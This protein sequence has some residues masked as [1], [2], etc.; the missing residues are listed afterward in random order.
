[1]TYTWRPASG[2]DVNAITELTWTIFHEVETI[3]IPDKLTFKRN[4]TF[5]IVNQFFNPNGEIVS[6]AVDENETILAYTWAKAGEK[7]VWSDDEILAIRLAHVDPSL[8]PRV[9]LKLLTDMLDIWESFAKLTNINIISSN[10]MR[11]EQ[12]AFL[13]LHERRGYQIRGSYAYKK[14]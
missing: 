11:K 12:K 2:L 14:M 5:A 7:A 13:K 9:R 3:F 6:I 8:S 1:M 10:T 4:L